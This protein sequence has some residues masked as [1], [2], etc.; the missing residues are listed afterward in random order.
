LADRKGNEFIIT[1]RG[2]LPTLPNDLLRTNSTLEDLGREEPLVK[3]DRNSPTESSVASSEAY[4]LNSTSQIETITEA[5]QWA[6]AKDGKVVLMSRV[7]HNL[8]SGYAIEPI[9]CPK[10]N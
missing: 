5:R 8:S 9:T 6:I 1:G 2:G 10:R 3:S 4:N 7:P